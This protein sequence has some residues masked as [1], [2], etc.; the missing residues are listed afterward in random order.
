[1]ST[2]T[3]AAPINGNNS[4]RLTEVI[5]AVCPITGIFVGKD[6]DSTSVR[7]DYDPT[8]T[9]PQQQAAQQALAAFDWSAPA[10]AA[11]LNAQAVAQAKTMIDDA[12]TPAGKVLQ[13]LMQAANL[14]ALQVQTLV[15]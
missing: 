5:V 3:A 15:K 10:Q 1:M 11:W 14:T 13:A 12:T 2:V 9:A 7:I 6:G 8:A 4:Q